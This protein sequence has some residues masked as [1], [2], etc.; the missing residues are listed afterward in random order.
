[1]ECRKDQNL[2]GCGCTYTPCS[3]KGL[4][5]ECISYHKRARE[6]PACFFPDKSERSYDRSYEHFARLVAKGEV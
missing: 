5:C 2:K 3:R 1:M 6:L 4:C